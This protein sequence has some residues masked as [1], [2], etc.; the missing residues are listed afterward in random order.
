MA[1]P[2]PRKPNLDSV[3]TINEDGSRYFL[4]PSDVR[5][6]WTAWRR[7]FGIVLIAIYAALPWIPVNGAPAVFFDIEFR[8]FHFFGLTLVPQ[9]LWVMFFCITGLGFGLFFVTSLLGRLWCGWT[10]PYTVFLDHIYRRIERWI[11]GDAPARKLLAAAPWTASKI[12]KRILKHALYALCSAL[13]AHI[14]LSYFVSIERLYSFMGEGPMAH[15]TAFG[16]VTF[17]TLVLWFCFGYFREQFCIIMCPY[18]RIQSALTDDDTVVIGYDEVRG[19]PRGPKDK[20]EGDCI[21]CKRC[22]N[23]CPT[24]IDI[25]DGLQLECIGC[26]ACIDACDEIM[27]KV[28]R[29]TGLVRYDSMNGLSGKKR[30]FL[31][32]RIFAYTAL[33][34]LGLTAFGFTASK[35]ARPYTATFKKMAMGGLP[36]QADASSV[37][38]F[39]QL[40]F[41]NKRN[42]P[43]TFTA[44]LVDAPEG[45]VLGGGGQTVDVKAQGEVTRQFVVIAPTANYDGKTTVTL[46]V[47]A[48]PGDVEIDQTVT[49]LGP[50]PELLGTPDS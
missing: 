29:P 25:R 2:T 26:T 8:R 11:E 28:G 38:N 14:F 20:V 12:A 30:R 50:N 40:R 27:I 16:I 3:T 19:E 34:L 17:L 41:L 35:K 9:D 10:C 4:H 45:F 21:D 36:F 44:T 49:F 43:A 37:R 31:R 15:A 32:P 13:I 1:Q 6:K 46:R 42:Q 47:S 7:I 5:G 23:V 48:N 18:G 39:Y 22:V 33:S 24:G